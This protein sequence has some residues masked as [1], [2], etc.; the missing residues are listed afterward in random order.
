VAWIARLFSR[1]A[2]LSAGLLKH[3]NIALDNSCVARL[4]Y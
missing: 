3:A 1:R 4:T 2:A